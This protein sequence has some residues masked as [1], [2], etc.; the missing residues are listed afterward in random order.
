MK[1]TYALLTVLSAS[2][3]LA[4]PA[5]FVVTGDVATDAGSA[6]TTLGRREDAIVQ[7]FAKRALQLRGTIV[8]AR[9]NQKDDAAAGEDA[10]QG[11]D[12]AA[13]KQQVKGK[14]KDA[15]AKAGKLARHK[16]P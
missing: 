6:T 15:D 9:T 1:T 11:E 5:P 8:E 14:G 12:D 4:A 10:A 2:L 16:I 13:D 7:D 3:V